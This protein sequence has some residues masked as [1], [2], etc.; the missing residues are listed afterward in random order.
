MAIVQGIDG[1]AKRKGLPRMWQDWEEGHVAEAYAYARGKIAAEAAP[2]VQQGL[3]G[4]SPFE[5]ERKRLKRLVRDMA[6]AMQGRDD[7]S[8]DDC[9]EALAILRNLAAADDRPIVSDVDSLTPEHEATVRWYAEAA[10][11]EI[12]LIRSKGGTAA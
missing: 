11:K 1:W 8:S 10:E 12:G 6:R 7:V 4:P 2:G 5:G 3:G 9:R